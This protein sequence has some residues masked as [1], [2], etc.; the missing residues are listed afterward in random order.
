MEGQIPVDPQS[1]TTRSTH[2]SEA[3]RWGEMLTPSALGMTWRG[4]GFVRAAEG[5]TFSCDQL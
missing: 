2:L 3:Q 4:V 5:A 1:F